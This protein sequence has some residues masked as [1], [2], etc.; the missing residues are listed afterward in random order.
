MEHIR[1][2]LIVALTFTGFQLWEAW[3]K[4]YGPSPVAQTATTASPVPGQ[5]ASPPPVPNEPHA[6]AAA[7]PIAPDA[8]SVAVAKAI[9]I[10][11]DLF[12]IQMSTEG[13]T[14]Q[15][16]SLLGY[17]TST[18]V[19]APPVE[20]L[21]TDAGREFIQETGLTGSE[22]LPTHHSIYLTD[23][24]SYELA[25]GAAQLVVPLRWTS[26]D[27]V[28]V[29]KR[30]ILKRGEYVIT[31]E[32]EIINNSATPLRAHVYEQLKR[33]QESSHRGMVST[34]T[35]AAL[36]TPE[37]RFLTIK[38]DDLKDKPIAVTTA[39]AWVGIVQHY[40]VTA[41]IP[42]AEAP[43]HFYSKVLDDSH[44]LVGYQS[45]ETVVAPAAKQTLSSRLYIGPKRHDIIADVAPGLEYSVDFGKLWFIAKP[46]FITLRT[47]HDLT[48]NWGYAIIL[49]TL[50]LKLLFFPL[51]AAGYRSMANMRRVQPRMLALKERFGDDRAQL[52]Q[53]MMK[54]YKDEKINPLGGCFPILIQIPVFMA[55][56]WVL[57]ESVEM[58]QAPFIL[59]VHDLSEKDPFF[60]LPFLMGISMW[61]QQK[62]NPAPIDPMQAKVMQ[63]MP[64]MF[65]VFF[66]FFPSGL[67]LY[68]F[69]NNMLSI[70]QQWHITRAIEAKAA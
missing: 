35:G 44:Y 28:V 58:R 54:L 1:L 63:V 2:L 37:K 57:L 25:D 53:A 62:L 65:T 41:L 8:T 38:F 24:D 68:W 48:G 30:V 36:S 43:Y 42:P 15:S 33:N 34:F 31:I 61:A 19:G 14:L 29:E 66:A 45:P 32:H 47:I 9:T 12:E 51:S 18:A 69:V 46:L 39:D 7:T 23:S 26:A 60:V 70:A 50:L 4:D 59:W 52:N 27:G 5:T 21:G 49:V 64:I 20:L 67:V 13:G 11:T 16:V 40:F 10:K 55:L 3:Q 56:Y 22:S 17:P 6:T